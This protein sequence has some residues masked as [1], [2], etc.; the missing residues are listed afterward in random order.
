MGRTLRRCQLTGCR[1]RLP[2]Q[3]VTSCSRGIH[4]SHAEVGFCDFLQSLFAVTCH[5]FWSVM[6]AILPIGA[7]LIKILEKIFLQ[8]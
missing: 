8:N 5:S 4:L 6:Q 3:K 7:V 1:C 2:L